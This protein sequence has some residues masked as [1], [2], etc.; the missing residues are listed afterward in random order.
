[1][2]DAAGEAANAALVRA[3][4][5]RG[6]LRTPRIADAFRRVPRHHFLPGLALEAVYADQA[7]ALRYERGI[8]ISASSQPAMMAE[9]LELLQPM[10]GERV[11][12]IGTGSGYNAALLATLVGDDGRVVSVELDPELA[13]GARVHLATAGI[14]QVRVVSGDGSAGA[15]DDAPFDA[16]EA[17][18]GV[19]D[20]PAAWHAQLREGGRLVAPYALRS[21]QKIVAFAQRDGALRSQVVLDG[22]FMTLRGPSV[23]SEGSELALDDA[24]TVVLRV[25]DGAVLDE[26]ALRRAFADGPLPVAPARPLTMDTIWQGF[27]LWLVLHEER[28]CR[29]TAFDD[30]AASRVPAVIPDAGAPRGQSSTLGVA[31]GRELAVLASGGSGTIVA[32]YGPDDGAL[33]RLQAQLVAW[34]DAGRPGNDALR[35]TVVPRER[36][37]PRPAIERAPG[38]RVV[39]QPSGT[40][41]VRWS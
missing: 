39:E 24:A 38:A 15:P 10:P 41:V 11:L 16:L 13:D 18:V 6:V 1:M 17:T 28:C 37:A 3:L 26:R 32:R 22:A 27:A 9:M 29:L 7:I 25:R 20:L 8:A 31:F 34:D 4:L 40:V 30:V 12:E 2:R 33:A 19:A 21:V 23:Q 35:I 36:G 5:E 14:E